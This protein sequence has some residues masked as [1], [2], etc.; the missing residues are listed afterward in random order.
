MI[1]ELLVSDLTAEPPRSRRP[2]CQTFRKYET[3]KD[4]ASV[5]QKRQALAL[6]IEADLQKNSRKGFGVISVTEIPVACVI[7]VPK[8][9]WS[10]GLKELLKRNLDVIA[11]TSFIGMGLY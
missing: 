2:I 11:P 1:P 4:Y 6:Q 9:E 10:D 3:I 8:T 5:I 7:P